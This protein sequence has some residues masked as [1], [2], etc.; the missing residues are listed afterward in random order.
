MAEQLD[1]VEQLKLKG[2]MVLLEVRARESMAVDGFGTVNLQPIGNGLI[3]PI[4]DDATVDEFFIYDMGPKVNEDPNQP[5][6]EKGMKVTLKPH[7]GSFH[8]EFE[9]GLFVFAPVTA[10]VF[11]FTV[12]EIA[13]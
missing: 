6:L 11:G 2:C 1:S 4:F 5:P 3:L 9:E 12:M 10:I 13:V 7:P 8:L